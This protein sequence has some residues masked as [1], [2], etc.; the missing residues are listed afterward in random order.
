MIENFRPLSDPH[1]AQ[2]IAV[3]L[4]TLL[5]YA[6]SKEIVLQNFTFRVMAKMTVIIS[7]LVFGTVSELSDKKTTLN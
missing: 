6:G 2:A 1:K 7:N 3:C 4:A 5:I